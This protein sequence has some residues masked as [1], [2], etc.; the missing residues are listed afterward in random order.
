[1]ERKFVGSTG[2]IVEH[3]PA[4]SRQ[5]P[6]YCLAYRPEAQK[7]LVTE[8]EKFINSGISG[9]GIPPSLDFDRNFL[10]RSPRYQIETVAEQI[11]IGGSTRGRRRGRRGCRS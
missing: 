11:P 5:D 3:N 1:M 9:L 8:A 7:M 2:I 10:D 6:G 4:G